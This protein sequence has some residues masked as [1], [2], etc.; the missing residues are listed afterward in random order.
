MIFKA[1]WNY[2]DSSKNHLAR[3][4]QNSRIPTEIWMK[5]GLFYEQLIWVLSYQI[6]FNRQ[7]GWKNWFHGWKFWFLCE[8][9][10]ANFLI[11]DNFRDFS[12]IQIENNFK[13]FSW[14]EIAGKSLF[15]NSIILY[16]FGP[17]ISVLVQFYTLTTSWRKPQ[18]YVL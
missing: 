17:D 7:K 10:I 5:L 18:K 11:Y 12:S 13:S 1:G 9:Q 15:L 6:S 8:F 3:K 2:W 4:S 16:N 14:I